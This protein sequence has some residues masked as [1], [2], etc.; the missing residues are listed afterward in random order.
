MRIVPASLC[1][2]ITIALV[3]ALNSQLPSGE[4][5]TPRLGYFLSPQKGFWQ[6]AEPENVSFNAD[7]NIKELKNK[8]DVYFDERL[9][10]H[11]YAENDADAYFIQG[12]L[13]A[14][15]RLWQMEFQTYLAAGRL[16]EVVGDKMLNTDKYFRRLGMSYGAE[17]SLKLLEATPETKASVDAYTAGIN[18]YIGHLKDHDIPVEYKL[19]DYKPEPWTNFKTALFMKLMAYDL[20]GGGEEDFYMTNTK[21]F[22][23]YDTF[24]K[25][26]PDRAD[27]LDPIIPKG[28]VFEKPGIMPL[29]PAS[30]D[31]LYYGKTGNDESFQAPYVPNK[32]NGSNNWAV[33]GSKTKSGK[34]ILCNDPH[35]SLNLPSLWYELQITT[36]THNSYGVSFPG[37]PYVVIGFNDSCA[38]GFTNSG[39]DVKDFYEIK[40]K[41]STLQEYQYNGN[42]VKAETRKEVIKVKGKEDVIDQV[43]YTVFGP[44]MYDQHYQSKNKDNKTY[45]VSW[46]AQKASNELMMFEKLKSAK[47]F[48][49]YANAIEHLQCPGQNPVFAAVNGDIAIRQQGKFI[50]KWKHQGDFVMPGTD[51]AYQWQGFVDVKENA[52]MHN[53][54]RGFVSSANQMVTDST[55]PYYLGRSGNFPVYRG[56]L[57]NKRL[58]AMNNITVEDMERLQTNN[59]NVFAEMARP[60][61]LKNLDESK[62]N[63]EEKKYVQLLK[64][65]NLNNDYTEKGPTVFQ[66]FWDS[67]YHAV[68]DDEYSKSKL[69][70]YYPQQSTLLEALLRN[71][72]V[73]FA[74]NI[75]TSDKVETIADDVLLAFQKA[76]KKLIQLEKNNA[77][78]WGVYKA[79]A[80][81]H[82]LKLPGLSRLNL[83]IGG[84]TN[85]INAATG[86][87]GPS[88]R[89][90]VHLKDK[91]EAYVVYPGG[92]SGNP[93]SKFYDTF[94]D[95]WA[96]GKYYQVLFIKRDEAR[97]NQKMKWHISFTNA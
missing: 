55:Y 93:G 43:A 47:N 26:F 34:P 67:T 86:D 52:Q 87:H 70:L 16:S 64:D 49:D 48:D 84:G 36:P 94:I 30:I 21:N 12:Y 20:S 60:I 58:A 79:T 92:Q 75:N 46:M 71:D 13:H 22:F 9:V 1:G 39:R 80:V 25:L 85:E 18:Y 83:P 41:D 88:W 63:T 90:I 45:A 97:Q 35:L 23:G 44:V 96:V 5:K 3:V 7:I 95:D 40:F 78:Q 29:L 32:N 10:P 8:A 66:A 6:N 81:N 31:S 38:W 72:E 59:Y 27:S 54:A 82:L 51:S 69:P 61:L 76:C 57:I 2:V 73:I 4:S 65:W 28:T 14:K 15:F 91:V 19:L 33:A 74:D 11:I 77:L 62:L 68:Y 17:Q 89:M 53:P 56:Y 50:A 24:K 42:W 37:A